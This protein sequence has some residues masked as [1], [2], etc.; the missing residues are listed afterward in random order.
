MLAALAP[1]VA[2]APVAA[3]QNTPIVTVLAFDNAAFGPAA[4]DYDGIG[5]GIMDL[6]ITDLAT[7]GKVRV[8]DR[9]RVQSILD[10]QNLSKSGAIDGTTAVRVGRLLGACYSVYGSFVRNDKS[11]D[12]VLTIHTT[13]NETGQIQNAIKVQSKGDDMLDLIARASAQF[14]SQVDVK[15]CPG[16]GPRRTGDA[17]PAPAQQQSAQAQTQTASASQSVAQKPATPAA[18][19]PAPA[20]EVVKFANSLTPDQVKKIKNVKLDAR[21]MLI[22]SRALDAKDHKENAR[23]R[24]LAQQVLDKHPEFSPAETL[25]AS[26]N[27]GN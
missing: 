3:A 4:K 25:I 20:K 21:S 5:K 16:G 19:A 13:S 12:N 27:A 11:G 23:A 10:E 24:T 18:A 9:S 22:Y 17:S 2:F 26:L 15:A 1:L 14:A 7:G 8:V 6:V